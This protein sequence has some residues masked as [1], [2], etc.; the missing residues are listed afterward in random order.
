MGNSEAVVLGGSIAGLLCAAALAQRFDTVTVVD[1]DE[2]S[3]DP[4]SAEISRRGVPQ[5]NQVH[6]LLSLGR[7]RIEELLPGLDD[8]L[9]ALGC[10]HF[11]DAADFAQFT[12]GA[13]RARAHSD[14]RITCFRRP[15]FEWAIRRRVLAL[16]NV[17]TIAGVATGL[18]TSDDRQRVVGAQVN[19]APDGKVGCDLVVDATGRGSRAPRW[20]EDIGYDR[21]V[22][23]HLRVYMGYSTFIVEFPDGALPAGVAGITCTSSAAFPMGAAIRP[24][25]NGKHVIA[26]YG[27]MRNYPPAQEDG[28]DAFLRSLPTPL[29][30]Q[31]VAKARLLSPIWT[32]RMPGNQRRYW[33]DLERRPEGFVV[34]GD[35]VASFDPLYGQGMTM[36]AIGATVLRDA[37]AAAA[38]GLDGLA[39]TVQ[40]KL[41]PWTDIAFD[42][43]VSVDANFEGAEFVNVEPPSAG[44]RDVTRALAQVQ[45]ERPDIMVAARR[46]TL[47]MDHS[48]VRSQS[49]QTAVADWLGDG[50]HVKPEFT[51]PAV[52][53][54]AF[55]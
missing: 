17:R 24:V 50:R 3:V 54:P 52:I 49:V 7:D 16:A 6:H 21:P 28:I 15:L 34:V 40:K 46:A 53:P 10:A 35:A 42:T 9:L 12:S 38:G 41:S 39:G 31:V 30:A 8:E 4:G 55:A 14:L 27:M 19:G 36:A 37:V 47:Y 26:L 45:T 13:W 33:E 23:A 20:M 1:R 11:D 51:D 43:A 25:D 5:G 48:Y 44:A 22:E 2:L 32:Y 29:V 18:I